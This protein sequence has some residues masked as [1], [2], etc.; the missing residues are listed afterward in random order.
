MNTKQASADFRKVLRTFHLRVLRDQEGNTTVGIPGALNTWPEK[1]LR[2]PRERRDSEHRRGQIQIVGNF[3]H[4][5]I[6]LKDRERV[7]K[8]TIKIYL[9]H[10]VS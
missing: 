4:L 9:S 2:L 1:R 8:D 7:V 10:Q 3:S 6:C 5:L